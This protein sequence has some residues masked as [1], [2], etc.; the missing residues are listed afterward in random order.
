MNGY[1]ITKIDFADYGNP[2]GKC[3]EFRHCNCGAP[4]TLRLVKKNCLGKNTCALFATDKMF[5]PSHCKGVPKLAVEATCTK[6]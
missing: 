1:V 6:R 5:G 4:A 2:T 3:Q